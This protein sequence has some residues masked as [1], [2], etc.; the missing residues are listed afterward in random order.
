MRKQK[1]SEIRFLSSFNGFGSHLGPPKRSQD[2]QKSMLKRHQ[3]LISFGRPLGPRFFRPKSR[4]EPPAPQIAAEDGVGPELLGEDLGGGR[5][6]PLRRRIRK[7]I[8][9]RIRG[10]G[11]SDSTRRPRLGGGLKPPWGEYRRP[12]FLE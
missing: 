10:A 12:T 6:G 11:V 4:Q 8:R 5:Q 9:R 7:E 3:N 2:A 1:I